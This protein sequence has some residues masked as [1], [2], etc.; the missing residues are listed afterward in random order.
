MFSLGELM[1]VPFWELAAKATRPVKVAVLDTGVDATHETLRG[2]VVRAVDYAAD[3]SGRVTS[4]R[5]AAG[6]H[7]ISGHGTG[8]ASIVSSLAPNA[9]L[10][11]CRVLTSG[12][13]GQGELVLAGLEEAIEGDA[14]IVNLS[15]AFKKDRYWDRTVKL[16][17]RAYEK[18]KIVVASKRNLALPGDLGLPA[19][20]AN[21][22]SVDNGAFRG[23]YCFRYVRNSRIEFVADGSNVLTARAGGGYVR[24]TGTSFATPVVSAFCALLRGMKHDLT[25]F[26]LKALLK[27]HA[28]R[29]RKESETVANPLEIAPMSDTPGPS[30]VEYTCP[31][32]GTKF[33]VPDAFLGVVCRTC[34]ANGRRRA[35]LDPQLYAEL[36]ERIRSSVPPRY[37]FHDWRHARDVV[38]A[39]YRII[40]HHPELSEREK[41]CLLKAALL[42][43]YG[44]V[45][46][47]R[48]HE[49]AGARLAREIYAACQLPEVELD[50]IERLVLATDPT[51]EPDDLCGAIMRDADM[52]HMGTPRMAERSELL[53]RELS[54]EGNHVSAEEWERGEA[55]FRRK[56]SFHLD[57]LKK[58][59]GM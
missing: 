30:R 42:H 38:E 5:L 55:D 50:M 29:Y 23:P 18:N 51:R 17:E 6:N 33:W 3:E 57:W 37:C 48:G 52:F 19:E 47:R 25:V 2:K 20:L 54:A 53:R 41:R 13:G 56:F 32:C 28:D 1:Q 26:E 35:L 27:N 10:I 21:T 14:E 12:R 58:E 36:L 49:V 9:R 15:I 31:S 22:V 24:M 59:R 34:G 39:V 8:V 40:P 4:S 16:L 44:F 46:G 43:D 7:D 11:D 45:F